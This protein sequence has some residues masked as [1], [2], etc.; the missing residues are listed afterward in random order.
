VAGAETIFESVFAVW[1]GLG[2]H[3]RIGAAAH[4]HVQIILWRTGFR[5]LAPKVLST[6]C[7]RVRVEEL[8]DDPQILH[9]TCVSQGGGLTLPGAGQEATSIN[10]QT[11]DDGAHWM[12]RDVEKKWGERKG[13]MRKTNTESFGEDQRYAN[14]RETSTAFCSIRTH[15]FHCIG[16][17]GFSQSFPIFNRRQA[18][19]NTSVVKDSGICSKSSMLDLRDATMFDVL[20][21]PENLFIFLFQMQAPCAICDHLRFQKLRHLQSGWPRVQFNEKSQDSGAVYP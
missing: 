13:G 8:S 19:N 5:N 7:W 20:E 12:N 16:M 17:P 4:G 18:G 3:W 1:L 15:I 10:Q 21:I 11:A 6:F 9:L 14:T 2:Q